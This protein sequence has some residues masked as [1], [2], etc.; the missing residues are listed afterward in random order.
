MVSSNG[1]LNQMRAGICDMVTIARYLNVTLIVPELDNTS[2]W[3]DHSQFQDIFDVNYFITSL[4][5]QV[6]IL[7]EL[8][9]QQKKK[10]EQS[11]SIPCHPLAGPT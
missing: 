3:N 6:R 1:G 4:R 2:F 11:H 5:D 9:P 7:K 8:P 10:V